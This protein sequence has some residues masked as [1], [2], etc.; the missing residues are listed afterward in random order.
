MAKKKRKKVSK[1][2]K[3]KMKSASKGAVRATQRKIKLVLR[4]LIVFAVLGGVTFFLY[5]LSN[6]GFFR[7]LFSLLAMVFGFVGLAFLIV[8]LALLILKLMKK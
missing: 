3:K 6:E 8:L 2:G 1:S 5:W 7:N 4:N